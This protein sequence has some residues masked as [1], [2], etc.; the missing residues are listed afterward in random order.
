VS[1]IDDTGTSF[2]GK[3]PPNVPR[4]V[5]NAGT[6]YR[7]PTRWPVELGVLVRHVGDRFTLEDNLIVMNAY[8]LVDAYAF[9]DIDPRDLAWQGVQKARVTFRVKN[10]ADKTY[11]VWADPGYPDQI[12]LGA[13]R[14]YEVGALFKF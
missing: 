14:T 9:L 5:A 12:I 2:A 6:S 11:A 10:V 13:P 7:F 3:T 4:I 8:T 1:F